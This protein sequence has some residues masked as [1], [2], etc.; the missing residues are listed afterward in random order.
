MDAGTTNGFRRQVLDRLSTELGEPDRRGDGCQWIIGDATGNESLRL[1]LFLDGVDTFADGWLCSAQSPAAERVRI[2]E[3]GALETLIHR[4]RSA[5]STPH[6]GP[7]EPELS[8]EPAPR[9][10]TPVDAPP[11][12]KRARR[13]ATPPPGNGAPNPRK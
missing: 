8:P 10:R 12:P 3:P 5:S 2:S 9:Q 7:Q 1:T 4:C 11:A 13:T 6:A